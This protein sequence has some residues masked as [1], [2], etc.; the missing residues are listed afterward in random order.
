[1]AWA[2]GQRAEHRLHLRASIIL[3]LAD[4]ATAASVA[5]DLE[6]SVKTVK[7]WR[8]R[9]RAAGPEGLHD[10]PRS[11]RPPIFSVSQRYEVIALACDT[12]A[13]YGHAEA[14]LR[15]VGAS[16]GPDAGYGDAQR[17]PDDACERLRARADS[18]LTGHAPT[19]ALWALELTE[20][21]TRP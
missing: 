7:K 5:E 12:P 6:V 18:S 17:T 2:N 19:P 21:A 4:G 9:F 8:T 15:I 20:L 14:P 13:N 16:V 10:E 1:M 11:G 3:Q